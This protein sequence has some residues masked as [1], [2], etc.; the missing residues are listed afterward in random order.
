MRK[1]RKTL[2]AVVIAVCAISSLCG[3]SKE[4]PQANNSS[5]PVSETTTTVHSDIVIPTPETTVSTTTVPPVI[6]TAVTTELIEPPATTT[7]A[8]VPETEQTTTLPETEAPVPETTT[9]VIATT[10][11]QTEASVTTSVTTIATTPTLQTTPPQ[12]EAP[13]DVEKVSCK[14]Y[15]AKDGV[16]RIYN[17]V[18][19]KQTNSFCEIKGAY[20]DAVEYYKDKSVYK[21]IIREK[22][23][24]I[25][26]SDVTLTDPVEA[27]YHYPFDLEAIRQRIIDEAVNDYGLILNE[28]IKK[29]ESSWFPPRVMTRNTEAYILR[30]RISEMV[31][32]NFE[33]GYMKAGDHFNVYIEYV[34]KEEMTDNKDGT[35][36]YAIFFLR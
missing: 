23:Y 12:T 15:L 34:P 28:Q 9:T 19:C 24:Y 1:N 17:D 32:T 18:D 7:K 25:K 3:C 6:G 10:I 11:P 31:A 35:D 13:S 2:L 14:V 36:G 21:I 20:Y 26:S 30:Q 8:P 5:L 33:G 29:D 16:T 22:E 27:M 4:V